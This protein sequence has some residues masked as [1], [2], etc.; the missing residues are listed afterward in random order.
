ME[1]TNT[2]RTLHIVLWIVQVLLAAMLLWAGYTKVSQ[3]IEE[4]A[5]KL[6]WAKD[7]PLLLV[8]FIGISELAGALG[9]IL[10]SL[11]RIQSELTVWAGIGIMLIMIFAAVFHISRAEYT[12][13]PMN[14][15]MLVAGAFV[16]WGRNSQAVIEDRF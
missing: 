16:A 8:R 3:P 2:S 9:L 1:T 14:V 13:I 6:P 5:L 4:L 11:L 12:Y 15:V 10:P 7:I